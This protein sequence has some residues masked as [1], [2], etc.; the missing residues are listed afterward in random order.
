MQLGKN[1]GEKV[2]KAGA[3]LVVLSIGAFA[4]EAFYDRIK[5]TARESGR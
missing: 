2:L 4:D 5:E 3:N 1:I